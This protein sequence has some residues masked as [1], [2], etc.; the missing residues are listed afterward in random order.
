VEENRRLDEENE[1]LKNQS[2]QLNDQVQS[3]TEQSTKQKTA[4]DALKQELERILQRNVA[5]N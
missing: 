1:K 3:L 4:I 2:H 5:L